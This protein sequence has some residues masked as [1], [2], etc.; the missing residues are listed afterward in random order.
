MPPQRN[1]EKLYF[2]NCERY[3]KG[4]T[5]N[6]S[7]S[8][9]QRHAPLRESGLS[10]TF[11]MSLSNAR[12]LDDLAR[13]GGIHAITQVRTGMVGAPEINVCLI[14]MLGNNLY[15]Q[16]EKVR[17]VRSG[18]SGMSINCQARAIVNERG[19]SQMQN[20]MAS[21]DISEN[22]C[23]G[24]DTTGNDIAGA[25]AVSGGGEAGEAQGQDNMASLDLGENTYGSDAAT[26][27]RGLLGS[28]DE[29]VDETDQMGTQ[30]PAGSD[31]ADPGSLDD[32]TNETQGNQTEEYLPLQVLPNI[33]LQEL[34]DIAHLKDMKLAMEFIQALQE[35]SLDDSKLDKDI[36]ERLRN[37]PTYPADVGNPDLQL[38]L[39][40][41]LA[42]TNSSQETYASSREAIMLRHPDDQIPSYDQIKRIIAD[43]T[44]VVPI[45][46]HMCPNSCLAYTGP[47]GSLDICPECGEQRYNDTGRRTPRQ[48]FYTMPLGPLL[49]A[50]WRDRQ[51]A[52]RM[53]YRKRK[54]HE[55]IE[56]LQSN[57]GRLK[58][59]ND[60]L[61]S[62]EYLDAVRSGRIQP[63]DT[64]LM[65]S[66]DGAQLYAHK[67]SD[68]WIYIWILFDLD[69]KLRYQI[70][71][72]LPGGIIPGPNKP[73]NCDSYLFPG[74][75]HV[76][77]LQREGLR[78]WDASLNEIFTSHPF[79]ALGTADGPGMTYL[80]GLVGHHGK[81]GCRLYCSVIGRHKPGGSHY[82]PALLKPL[83]YNVAGSDHD[84]LP[85]ADLPSCSPD[86]YHKN[87]R[88]LLASPNETQYKKR[89]LETGISKPSI[90][91]GLQQVKI[92]GIPGCF[93]SD[94]MHLASLNIPDLLINLWR[95]VFDCDKKDD[96]A[97]WD[98]A[99]L[100]GPTWEAHGRRVAS[101]TPYLPGSFDRP[102]RNPA[103]KISSG[104]KAWEFLLYLYGLG[105]GIFYDVLP[106]KY[107]RHFCKLVFGIRITSQYSIKTEDINKAHQALL[108]FAVEF[109]V[110]YYQRRP[111]RLH[112]V[113][114][115]I[116]A[117]THL[118]P[119]ALRIGPATCSSQWTMERTI[120]N[121]GRE[122][123]QPSNPFANL[124]QR[125]LLRCQNN[126]IKAMVPDLQR[127][128]TDLPQGAKDVGDGYIL[129]RARDRTHRPM[130]DC[131][132]IALGKYLES[133]TMSLDGNC[134]P[135]IVRWARL[136]LPNGQVARSSWKEK[137]KPL[138]KLRMAR[139]VKV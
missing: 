58:A 130:R 68:C 13:S 121:L 86:I 106:E 129:L 25:S 35:A 41:F 4:R 52:E 69:P 138:T 85:Y 2:C 79:L 3:C 17:P 84:D 38:G 37:P 48:E 8:T 63:E 102:P 80:N 9:Y 77:A 11:A 53:S 44:G 45:I 83:N 128:T 67:A 105:P 23:G 31:H 78:I 110:L 89:R 103:E 125:G 32:E 12:T 90:F 33:D 117:L 100:H 30:T 24:G 134:Y 135:S 93:G 14:S 72:V 120:G 28:C 20:D 98:W 124:S 26:P 16:F 57:D 51:S 50:L 73:K 74:L 99:V 91:L 97:T 114:Q 5:T 75:H 113:R 64:V 71:H 65:L 118:G 116:H 42:M 92:L 107:W 55:I 123:R 109:E 27:A 104:Y 136:R 56:E 95:G 115:S 66:I 87:L 126:V 10:N 7:R 21:F 22:G 49:Q 29:D 112:F 133:I 81:N 132:A 54:T 59:I 119:E 6:V 43:I 36:I 127:P 47:F 137:L 40:L 139:N 122:I 111:E 39:R 19:E 76:A 1:N 61:Y 88:H 82:Y 101:A 46:E 18:S 131:E 60:F 96:R 15:L 62:V 34:S 108:E 94:I 70:G